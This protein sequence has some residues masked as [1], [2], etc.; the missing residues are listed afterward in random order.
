MHMECIYVGMQNSHIHKINNY[1]RRRTKIWTSNVDQWLKEPAAKPDLP[2]S[3]PELTPMR[4]SLTSLC[5]SPHTHT[6]NRCNLQHFFPLRSE[7]QEFM[8]KV[9][10]RLVPL[11]DQGKSALQHFLVAACLLA[12]YPWFMMLPS[13]Q[14]QQ[15][16]LCPYPPT[17]FSLRL[18]L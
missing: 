6:N 9:L 1:K 10:P 8:I 11:K 17:A 15:A 7:G 4:C 12:S 2:S 14:T 18:C 13:L 3:I 16:N 5:T